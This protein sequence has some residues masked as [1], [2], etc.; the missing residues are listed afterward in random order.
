VEIDG[1]DERQGRGW[2]LDWA[3]RGGKNEESTAATAVDQIKS[4]QAGFL[5]GSAAAAG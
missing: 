1:M 5:D 2:R 3:G 4:V